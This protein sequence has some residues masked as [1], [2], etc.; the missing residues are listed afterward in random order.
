MSRNTYTFKEIIT[1]AENILCADNPALKPK[2]LRVLMD[3][4]QDLQITTYEAASEII[5][6]SGEYR[7]M[8]FDLIG[9]YMGK[10]RKGKKGKTTT[11]PANNVTTLAAAAEPKW[12][13]TATS[14]TRTKG[15]ITQRQIDEPI[16]FYTAKAKAIIDYLV[17]MSPQEI[18]WLG[19]VQTLQN[20]YLVDRIYVPKQ[21]VTQTETDIDEGAMAALAEELFG[22]GIDPSCLFYWGHSHVNMGVSP[23]GQDERQVREYLDSCP[24][25]IRE[26]RNKRGEVKVDIYD[27]E[28]RVVHQCVQTAVVYSLTDTEKAHLDHV[29]ASNVRGRPAYVY[30]PPAGRLNLPAARGRQDL[31]DDYDYGV[32]I[33]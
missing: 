26:I 3:V 16:L 19:T 25:F 7:N 1:E 17:Q 24:I 31:I 30:T 8:K 14:M 11:P 13:A 12:R 22:A 10:R 32:Y 18:G 28:E 33:P 4:A 6:R 20:G 29:M 21:Q 5:L 2:V 15:F 23:S 9:T 27:R